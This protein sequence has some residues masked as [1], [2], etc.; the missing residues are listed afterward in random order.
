MIRS[1]VLMAGT[2]E[3][4]KFPVQDKL[5]IIDGQVYHGL[6]SDSSKPEPACNCWGAVN[7][8]ICKS[9]MTSC[10][11]YSRFLLRKATL[12]FTVTHIYGQ[13][14]PIS[15]YTPR[16]YIYIWLYADV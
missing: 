4:A 6:E 9:T 14:Q 5:D 2:H 7:S 12:K 3:H 13:A 8:A 10:I 16:P 11:C 15:S 1:G